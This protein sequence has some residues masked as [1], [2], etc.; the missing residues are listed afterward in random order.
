MKKLV[1]QVTVET[2]KDGKTYKLFFEHECHDKVT[3]FYSLPGA[4]WHVTDFAPLTVLPIIT[5]GHCDLR[6]WWRK[7][8]WVDAK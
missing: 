2:S 6:G 4:I 7:G 1:R 8:D 5:C 3:M